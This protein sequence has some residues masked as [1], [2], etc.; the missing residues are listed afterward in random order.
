M[1]ADTFVYILNL[2][3]SIWLLPPFNSV[4]LNVC[5]QNGATVAVNIGSGDEGAII[6]DT[7][8]YERLTFNDFN[9]QYMLIQ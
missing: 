5:G 4:H 3:G 2:S 7:I 6:H 1:T 8:S 9:R